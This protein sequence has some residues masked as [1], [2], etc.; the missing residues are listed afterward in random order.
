MDEFAGAFDQADTVHLLDIY[1]ASEV[2]IDGVT[3]QVLASRIEALGH[4]GVR[5]A[6]DM[7]SA[8]ASIAAAAQPDDA[9]VTLGAGSVSQAGP[10]ILQ[11]L[12]GA[13]SHGA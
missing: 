9:I 10:L 3:S 1:A 2:P 4:R 13:Q 7:D 8:I 6:G 11:K 5:Y 12:R